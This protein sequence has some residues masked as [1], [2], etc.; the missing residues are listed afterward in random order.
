MVHTSLRTSAPSIPFV[1]VVAAREYD[2]D[3][4][5]RS[6]AQVRRQLSVDLPRTTVLVDEKRTTCPN[7]VCKRAVFPRMCTQAVMAPVVE[8]FVL[9]GL[10]P[11]EDAERREMVVRVQSRP[12]TMTVTKHLNIHTWEGRLVAR[13]RIAVSADRKCVTIACDD[14]SASAA[15]SDDTLTGTRQRGREDGR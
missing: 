7:L 6:P 2:A 3:L 5:M 15:A 1:Y 11:H 4:G 10:V 9:N 13:V 12:K 14:A 8:H